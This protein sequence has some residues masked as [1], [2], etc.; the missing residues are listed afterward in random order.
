MSHKKIVPNIHMIHTQM[1][2]MRMWYQMIRE[3]ELK[4][5]NIT[6]TLILY[7]VVI[8]DPQMHCVII[9]IS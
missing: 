4:N 9:I 2:E 6:I 8:K 3:H 7:K 1:L 5:S